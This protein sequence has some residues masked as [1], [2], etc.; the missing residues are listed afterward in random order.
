MRVRHEL[1]VQAKCPVD[2]KRDVYTCYVYARGV[3]KVEDILAAVQELTKD[4]RPV[5]QEAFTQDLHR[6]LACKVK[7]VGYHSGVK[8]LAVSG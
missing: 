8:T 4:D 6:A 3:V 1:T 7:T 5:F 2:N